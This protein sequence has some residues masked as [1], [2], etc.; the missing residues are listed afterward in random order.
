MMR[1]MNYELLRSKHEAS[2]PF[3][4]DHKKELKN[5]FPFK[6]LMLHPAFYG[7]VLTDNIFYVIFHISPVSSFKNQD[8]IILLM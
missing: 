5:Q 4:R 1:F 8:E 6:S 7:S 2:T 3:I